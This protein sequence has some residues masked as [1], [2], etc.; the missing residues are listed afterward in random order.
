MLWLNSVQCY[1]LKIFKTKTLIINHLISKYLNIFTISMFW[2][3][4]KLNNFL[5]FGSKTNFKIKSNSDFTVVLWAFLLVLLIK[6][7]V[8]NIL[9]CNSLNVNVIYSLYSS[10]LIYIFICLIKCINLLVIYFN[11]VIL[12]NSKILC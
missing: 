6:T 12:L 10:N 9:I 5:L 8:L 1:M 3:P 7:A 4:K 11:F 2:I